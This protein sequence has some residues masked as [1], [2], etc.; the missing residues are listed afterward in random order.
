MARNAARTRRLIRQHDYTNAS[1]RLPGKRAGEPKT[2]A[3]V[4]DDRILTGADDPPSQRLLVS[5]RWSACL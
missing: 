2:A 4:E 5:A 1:Q 3:V